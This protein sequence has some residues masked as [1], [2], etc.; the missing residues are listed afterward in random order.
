VGAP[1]V[2]ISYST[3][4]VDVLV[5]DTSQVVRGLYCIVIDADADV[6]DT[7]V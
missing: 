2:A 6:V 4:V 7:V 3:G 5:F 1:V